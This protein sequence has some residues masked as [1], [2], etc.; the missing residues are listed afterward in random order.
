MEPDKRTTT[1]TVDQDEVDRAVTKGIDIYGTPAFCT[2]T[3]DALRKIAKTPT[4]R[5]LLTLLINRIRRPPLTGI[6]IGS[7]DPTRSS[8]SV[9]RDILLARGPLICAIKQQ[10]SAWVAEIIRDVL[11]ATGNSAAWLAGQLQQTPDYRRDGLPA[12]GPS[13]VPVTVAHV[14][15]WLTLAWP[16]PQPFAGDQALILQNSLKIVLAGTGALSPGPGVDS[17]VFWNQSDTIVLTNGT[18]QRRPVW[19]GLA[20]ELIH[21]YHN[22]FGL[23]LDNN[24]GDES[25]QVM[26][27]TVLGEYM[28]VGLGPWANAWLSGN[29]IRDEAGLQQRYMY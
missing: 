28:C 10:N 12:I 27:T 9:A 19:L 24:E 5:Q 25:A 14:R 13:S 22:M 8:K 26:L 7:I 6:V 11:I 2:Q 17:K 4:G 1:W 20:H 15:D 29:R 16:F 21:A 18:E 3:I 23:Q